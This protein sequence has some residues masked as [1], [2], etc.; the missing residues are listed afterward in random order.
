MQ[1]LKSAK[2]VT[3]IELM[4]VV[5]VIGVIA[6]IAIPAYGDYVTQSRRSEAY[7]AL[8]LLADRQEKFFLR[9]NSYTS[10]FSS[11]G[12]ST[13][14]AE[15]FYSLSI[16][17]GSAGQAHT[18]SATAGSTQVADENCFTIELNSLGQ[19]TAKNK[20]GTAVTDCW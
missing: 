3:L 14:S 2:G 15:G 13:T 18:L 11:L 7:S 5:A 20:A 10:D 4:I 12:M 8:Q 19:R 9:S 17:L 1:K 6:A 16:V